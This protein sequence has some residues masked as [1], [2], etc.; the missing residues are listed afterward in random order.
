MLIVSMMAQHKVHRCM[1]QTR[2]FYRV[3]VNFATLV[4]INFYITGLSDLQGAGE[5][6]RIASHY[7][8]SWEFN[9]YA[10]EMVYR[11]AGGVVNVGRL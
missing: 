7:K 4:H 8:R 5:Q 11:S 10:A 1:R 6:D 9:I 3:T 2:S